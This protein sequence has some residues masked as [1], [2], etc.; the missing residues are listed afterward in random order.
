MRAK[1]TSRFAFSLLAA[2]VAAPLY[3]Q[4]AAEP[5]DSHPCDQ[6]VSACKSAGFVDG[7]SKAGKGLWSEC[8]NPLMRGTTDPNKKMGLP[9]VSP[10]LVSACHAKDP[11]FGEP[12]KAKPKE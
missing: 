8:I 9:K 1:W 6:I 3:A 4:T 11:S 12:R 5:A 7:D 2:S 10:E